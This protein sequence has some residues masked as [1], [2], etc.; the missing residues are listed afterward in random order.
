LIKKKWKIDNKDNEIG[1]GEKL[2]VHKQGK[3]HRAISI[4]ILNEKEEILIQK[5]NKNKYHSGGLWSNACCTHPRP[6]EEIEEA[7]HRR[8]REEMGFDCELKRIFEFI[9]KKEFENGLI[10][11]EYDHVFLGKY[12]G[13][14][15]ANE[16]EAEDY[17]WRSL[18]ELK[19][20]IEKNPE[21][22]TYWFKRMIY[23]FSLILRKFD[24]V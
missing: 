3:M 12:D 2:E 14:V 22:Y 4:I 17:K 1:H 24:L 13:P 19:K 20:D 6:G 15:K 11:W 8:L 16:D 9:Y 7:A 10:E 18:E 21:K 23:H 5:R